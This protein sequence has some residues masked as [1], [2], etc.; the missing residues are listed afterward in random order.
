M[1]AP[2]GF[3]PGIEVLQTSHGVGWQ[4]LVQT[5]RGDVGTKK[6]GPAGSGPVYKG[7]VSGGQTENLNRGFESPSASSR[8]G[9]KE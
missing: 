9:D 2:P 5:E 4:P 7:V 1:E 6:S 8:T 3:E